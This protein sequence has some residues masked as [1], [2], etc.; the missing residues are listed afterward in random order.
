MEKGVYQA[1][2]HP[3][4]VSHK[5]LYPNKILGGKNITTQAQ[6]HGG[7]KAW[8]SPNLERLT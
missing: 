6:T 7:H 2:Q 3:R 8:Q 1:H 5:W 4:G